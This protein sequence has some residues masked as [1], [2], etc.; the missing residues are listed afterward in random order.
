MS[1]FLKYARCFR[2]IIRSVLS[3]SSPAQIPLFFFNVCPLCNQLWGPQP[4]SPRPI[5]SS[6]ARH[7]SS[8][9]Y[10]PLR[11]Q[12][13]DTQTNFRKII[14]HPQTTIGN[15]GRSIN[16]HP[17]SPSTNLSVSTFRFLCLDTL[18][19]SSMTF[20]Q[21]LNCNPDLPSRSE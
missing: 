1:T 8:V 5:G 16:Q 20:T 15:I 9:P 6:S 2:Q 4:L 19:I 11:I 10:E 21:W 17:P 18:P 7:M 12:R 14:R 13:Q 3:A